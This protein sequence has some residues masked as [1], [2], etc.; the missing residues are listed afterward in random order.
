MALSTDLVARLDRAARFYGRGAPTPVAELH[1]A[2]AELGVPVP[3]D[4][5]EFVARYGG[6]YV[7]VSVYGLINSASEEQRSVVELTRSFRESWHPLLDDALVFSFDGS[8]NPLWFD[9]EGRVLLSDHDNGEVV[10]LAEDFATLLED[11][12]DDLVPDQN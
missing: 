5:A 4:Y 2:C 12:V 7:G 1:Q 10:V 6:C 9:R 3:P 8:D 11:C